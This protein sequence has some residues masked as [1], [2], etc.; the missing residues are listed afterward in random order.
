MRYF[1]AD[2]GTIR[3]ALKTENYKLVSGWWVASCSIHE[4]YLPTWYPLGKEV[5]H[6]VRLPVRS[7]TEMV[8]ATPTQ[9]ARRDETFTFRAGKA[10]FV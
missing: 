6:V 5:H 2:Q 7:V 9:E 10:T 3:N 1:D 8:N 4:P